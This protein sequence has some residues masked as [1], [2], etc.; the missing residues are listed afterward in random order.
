MGVS[1]ISLTVGMYRN[2]ISLKDTSAKIDKVQERLATGK[3]V[4]SALD[5]PTNY[6]AAQASLNRASDLSARKDGIMEAIKNGEA[7]NVGLKAIVSMVETAIGIASSA[8]TANASDR[9]SLANQFNEILG[10]I[11]SLAGDSGYR[12]TNLLNNDDLTI[13]FNENGSSNLT[14]SGVDATSGGL[15]IQQISG[16]SLP[17]GMNEIGTGHNPDAWTYVNYSGTTVPNTGTF[18]ITFSVPAGV[19]LT[20]TTIWDQSRIYNGEQLVRSVSG[21]GW[22]NDITNVSGDTSTITI[23]ATNSTAWPGGVNPDINNGDQFIVQIDPLLTLERTFKTGADPSMFSDVFVDGVKQIGNYTVN[24]N[25]D[26]IFDLGAEPAVGTSISIDV[27]SI[28]SRPAWTTDAGISISENQL[29]ASLNTLRTDSMAL[30][31]SLSVVAVR[32]DF[33]QQMINNLETGADNLTLA[34]MNEEGANML[35]LQTRQN[36]GVTSLGLASQASQSVTKLFA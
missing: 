12:G 29:T 9:S 3:R 21:V 15:G 7:A 8:H 11:D 1:E 18:T 10:Q 34:D 2:L 6:F 4:N 30:S 35:M 28:S 23:T 32:Q 19:D 33:T 20:P 24:S 27:T 22:G 31:S 14:I 26:I 5:N 16:S 36:L 25:G 17:L 13:N